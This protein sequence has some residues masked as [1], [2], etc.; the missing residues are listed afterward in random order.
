MICWAATSM[1]L[2]TE[3]RVYS[4]T[5]HQTEYKIEEK[6]CP[7]CS[8]GHRVETDCTEIRPT[9]CLPCTDRTY[10]VMPN[11]LRRCTP[12]STCDSGAGLREKQQCR[13]SADTVC[14]PKEGLFCTNSTLQGCVV[15]QK[16]KSCKPGQYISRMGTASTDTECLSCTSGTFS[17]G[18]MLTCQPHTQC[19]KENLQLIKAGTASTDAECGENGS[20]ILGVVIGVL[21]PGL[22]GS[23]RPGNQVHLPILG[24]IL[25]QR[26]ELEIVFQFSVSQIVLP[27]QAVIEIGRGANKRKQA[28]DQR[29]TKPRDRGKS[30]KTSRRQEVPPATNPGSRSDQLL[31]LYP[32]LS[33]LPQPTWRR[34]GGHLMTKILHVRKTTNRSAPLLFRKGTLLRLDKDSDQGHLKITAAE[35]KNHRV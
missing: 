18:T 7:L 14:E 20:N 34:D 30:S 28:K 19:E 22:P 31:C 11:G 12:C 1:L 27:V 17:S 10:M 3:F 29:R 5:C 6:C 35:N 25:Y 32:T 16:H 13:R 33:T 21:H 4:F 15:T 23:A 8:P 9:S 26:T 24:L 2:M